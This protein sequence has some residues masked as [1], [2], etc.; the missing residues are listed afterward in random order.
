MKTKLKKAVK[1]LSKAL[2][3]DPDYFRAYQANIAMQ[4]K[5]EYYRKKVA[6][7]YG[8]INN[9]DVHQIANTAATSFLELLIK[10]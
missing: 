2:R 3:N 10:K 6:K 4:F 7:K 8:Y 9:E 5:D 1:T